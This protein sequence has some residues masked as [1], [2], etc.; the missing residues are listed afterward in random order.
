MTKRRAAVQESAKARRFA[1]GKLFQSCCHALVR[2][3][4]AG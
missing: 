2:G 4:L 1:T 3:A